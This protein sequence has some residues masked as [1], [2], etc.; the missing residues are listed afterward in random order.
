MKLVVGG[1]GQGKTAFACKEFQL[2]SS[3]VVDGAAA[4]LEELCRYPAVRNYH[5][6]LKQMI[7]RGENLQEGKERLLKEN[8]NVILI[9][10]EI[11]CGLV[12]M[13]ASEREYRDRAGHLLCEVAAEAE[14]VYRVFCGI[15]R[16]IK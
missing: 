11:G 13:D 9:A 15:G 8:P 5:L 2:A 14:H 16:V 6:F 12:P 3:Q 1:Y 10:D 4:S 7:E